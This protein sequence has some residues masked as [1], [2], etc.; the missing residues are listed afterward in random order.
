MKQKRQ[1][2]NLNPWYVTGICEIAGSFT[3]SRTL[4]N[5]AFYFAIKLPQ[6]QANLLQRIRD[7]FG[8]G[9]IY[10]VKPVQGSIN[11]ALYLRVT[12]IGQLVSIIEHFEKYPVQGRNFMRYSIWKEMV[13]IK[14][15]YSR[16]K[17]LSR[18]DF[19][20]L[21]DL[22]RNLSVLGTGNVLSEKPIVSTTVS[23]EQ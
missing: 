20:H 12:G 13:S 23:Q 10:K 8:I 15:K 5:F 21:Q 6:S 22:A 14:L 18:E 9:T 2:S 19:N 11:P 4:R 3:F 17:R 7:F 16:R 1:K